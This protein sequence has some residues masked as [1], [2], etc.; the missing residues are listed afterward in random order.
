MFLVDLIV[1]VVVA[2]ALAGFFTV[3]GLTL[4]NK[5]LAKDVDRTYSRN[6]NARDSVSSF[7]DHPESGRHRAVEGRAVEDGAAAG[8]EDQQEVLH[9]THTHS[10]RS[11]RK[12]GPQTAVL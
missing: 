4:L 5:R 8:D 9:S 11:S 10:H 12:S 6:F 3:L 1:R 2:L 7:A